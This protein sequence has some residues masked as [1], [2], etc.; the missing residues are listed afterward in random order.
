MRR[1][2]R[3]EFNHVVFDLLG[4]DSAPAKA[5]PAEEVVAG[6]DNNAEAL[7]LPPV[8]A[9]AMVGLAPRLAAMAI[10]R[11]RS[12]SSPCLAKTPDL[13]CARSFL[14]AFGL[15]AWRRPVSEAELDSLMQVVELGAK[16]QDV[17]H[18]LNLA[19][20]ALLLSPAFLFRIEEGT[21][22]AAEGKPGWVRPTPYELAARLSFLL[23]RSVPDDELLAL[24]SSGKLADAATIKAQAERML[25][26][27]R[28]ER[29]ILDL[30]TQW[31]DLE[32][33][34][35]INKDPDIFKN[36]KDEMGGL[37]RQE[38]EA[39]V[40]HT[41]R[42]GKI[43]DLLAADF[44]FL[45]E[46]LAGY[47]GIPGV[48]G[49]NFQKVALPKESQ[50]R[51]F[52]TQGSFLATHAG[53]D[54]SSPT[55]RGAFVRQ[56]ILC[57]DLP[58]PPED[59]DNT[60]PSTSATKTTRERYERISDDPSCAVCH[61]Q[62]DPIG[63]G[64]E[65]FDAAAGLRTTENGISVDVRGNVLGHEPATFEGASQLAE[66]LGGSEAFVDCATK[67]WFRFA[68]GRLETANNEPS[69]VDLQQ[70]VKDGGGNVRSLILALTQSDDFLLLRKR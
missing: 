5:F 58:P 30:H 28:A 64:L 37:F 27:A 43:A 59:V 53:F 61:R 62:I 23:W 29:L 47:Y 45:N 50:R 20:Q 63:F 48:K 68:T 70:R 33:A 26:D 69:L 4:D 7:T 44:S 52:L 13:A 36:W 55:L 12:T 67:Q 46:T 31:W 21:G 15:K 24:A 38:T 16:N 25:D 22:E 32:K 11:G 40:L 54:Q 41:F 19:T 35:V 14:G 66:L 18:G 34:T 51:G 3:T 6:F 1:L 49:A 39:F 56:R 9:Q 65:A 17:A 8:L 2:T 42:E 57:D 10:D 60:P